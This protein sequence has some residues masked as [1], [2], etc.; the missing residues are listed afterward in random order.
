[1]TLTKYLTTLNSA[2]ELIMKNISSVTKAKWKKNIEEKDDT[3]SFGFHESMSIC[4]K[5]QHKN[6]Q[7]KSPFK[8]KN[9]LKINLIE[10]FEKIVKKK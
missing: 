1:M 3:F 7:K 10:T 9:K 8:V 2:P 6:Q 5:R 4:K